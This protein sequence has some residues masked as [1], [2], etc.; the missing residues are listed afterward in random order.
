MAHRTPTCSTRASSP[1]LRR[2]SARS[3]LDCDCFGPQPRPDAQEPALP[4]RHKASTSTTQTRGKAYPGTRILQV[5]QG[6]GDQA[7]VGSICPANVTDKTRDDY[8]YTPAVGALIDSLRQPLGEQC[9]PFALPV[10]TASGQ[11]PCSVIEVLQ[12]H[13]LPMRHRARSPH[14]G[15]RASHRRDEGARHLPVRNQAIE[16]QRT[17]RLPHPTNPPA[18]SGDGLVLRRSRR[19][20]ARPTCDLVQHVRDRPAASHSLPNGQQQAAPRRHD[21]SSAANSSPSRRPPPPRCP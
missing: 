19:S 3:R 20:R 6:L 12:Q 1:L 5:L 2:K 10:D 21:L 7:I 4:E 17:E 8:G 11:T 14:G 18:N 13:R 15:R 16:R 9:L